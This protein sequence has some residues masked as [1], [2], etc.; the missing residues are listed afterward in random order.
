[1]NWPDIVSAFTNDNLLDL[2]RE[3]GITPAMFFHLRRHRLIGWSKGGPAFPIA[4]SA[5][6]VIGLHS[7][8]PPVK[9]QRRNWQYEWFGKQKGVSPLVFGNLETAVEVWVFES[10][11]D[12]IAALALQGWHSTASKDFH[13]AAIATRGAL[14]GAT[15]RGLIS[16]RKRILAFPQNDPVKNPGKPTAAEKWLDDVVANAGSP[17]FVVKTPSEFKDLND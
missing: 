8:L 13:V 1:M 9:G 16:A 2:A 14:N 6:E 3:R 5:G 15:L 10:Q 17:V 7:R 4:N 12:A 11:W